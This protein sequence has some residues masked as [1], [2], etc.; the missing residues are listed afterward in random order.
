MTTTMTPTNQRVKLAGIK[1]H[2]RNYNRHPAKQIER[3]AMSLRKFGQVRSIVVWQNT[4]LAGH[5][6]VE[7]A[8]SLG[9]QSIVADVLPDEYPEHL[10]LAYVAADNELSRLSD[11]DQA[12]LAAI[13][14]ESMKTDD[15]LLQAIGYDEGELDKLLEEIEQS[16]LEETTD[17][18]TTYKIGLKKEKLI[19]VVISMSSVSMLESAI[20]ATGQ[21]ERGLALMDIC[22]FY[23]ENKLIDEKG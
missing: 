8:K 2:S 13:L 18:K 22:Q 16:A 1:T 23:L 9:W 20:L 5:G 15:E 11:P 3:I 21:R 10:A 4:I 12:A 14:E 7:A 6:V 19:R 17:S